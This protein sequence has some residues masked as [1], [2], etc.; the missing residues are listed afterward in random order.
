MGRKVTKAETFE[1]A[2]SQAAEIASQN[3][4]SEIRGKIHQARAQN[5]AVRQV[6]A[7]PGKQNPGMVT[8]GV[9]ERSMISKVFSSEDYQTTQPRL[10]TSNTGE[11]S[12]PGEGPKVW[13]QSIFKFGKLSSLHR[14]RTSVEIENKQSKEW[15]LLLKSNRVLQTKPAYQW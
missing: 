12:A 9:S 14:H 11:S 3:N 6:G 13:R 10:Q 4:S 7:S 8:S 15:T 2:A 5:D 1:K